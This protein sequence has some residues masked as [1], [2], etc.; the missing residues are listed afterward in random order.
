[1]AFSDKRSTVFPGNPSLNGL[2]KRPA[3]VDPEALRLSSSLVPKIPEFLRSEARPRP[4]PIPLGVNPDS[5]HYSSRSRF[6]AKQK[7]DPAVHGFACIEGNPWKDYYAILQEQQDSEVTIAHKQDMEHQIVAIK[8]LRITDRE[9]TRALAGCL[10]ENIVSLYRAYV[11][12]EM[13]FLIYECTDVSLAEVQSTPYGQ[14]VPYQMAAVC[15]EVS[16][17]ILLMYGP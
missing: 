3:E 4:P 12:D 14:L 8:Q 15:Q 13:I 10:H 11:E 2:G 6:P 7:H 1:M 5:A 16:Q 9:S 17:A